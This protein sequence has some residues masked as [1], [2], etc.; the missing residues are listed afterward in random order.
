MSNNKFMI[1]NAVT[2]ECVSS[3]LVKPLV[4]EL[5]RWV[6]EGLHEGSLMFP[7]DMDKTVMHY[8][9]KVVRD[10]RVTSCDICECEKKSMDM[11]YVCDSY[12]VCMVVLCEECNGG[13]R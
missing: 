3:D 2:G 9:R 1:A 11:I 12:D 4:G 5:K 13:K 10:N 8:F 7:I 6:K